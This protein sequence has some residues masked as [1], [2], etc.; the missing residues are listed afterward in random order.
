MSPD[1]MPTQREPEETE[2][3]F[4]ENEIIMEKWHQLVKAIETTTR[5]AVS[6]SPSFET[7]PPA[8][9]SYWNNVFTRLQDSVLLDPETPEFLTTPPTNNFTITLFQ[10][11]EAASCPCCLPNADASI[12][13][14]NDNGVTKGDFIRAFKEYMYGEHS[15]QVYSPQVNSRPEFDVPKREMGALVHSSDWMSRV[16]GEVYNEE[17]PNI[18]MYCCE[19]EQ[20]NEMTGAEDE[21]KTE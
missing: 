10:K 14:H 5:D 11:S 21:T 16:G 20:F 7:S 12:S 3:E 4:P 8:F 19:K 18:I 17:C 9:R 13:L 2:T 1:L 6:D 15:P